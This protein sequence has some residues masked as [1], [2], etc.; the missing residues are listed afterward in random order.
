[1]AISMSLLRKTCCRLSKARPASSDWMRSGRSC[2]MILSLRCRSSL[3][4]I[5]TRCSMCTHS[6]CLPS[7]L[8]RS[9]H[10]SMQRIAKRGRSV[11]GSIIWISRV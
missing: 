6:I 1:M 8:Q 2:I 3:C 11:A 5:G 7:A 10:S 9:Q 4:H